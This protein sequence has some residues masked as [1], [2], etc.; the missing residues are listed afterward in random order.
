MIFVNILVMLKKYDTHFQSIIKY[1][2]KLKGS[3]VC[4]LFTML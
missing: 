2:I 4:K 1:N 3:A